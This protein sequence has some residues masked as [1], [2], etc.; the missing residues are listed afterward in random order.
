MPRNQIT[1][2]IIL[3]SG[4]IGEIHKSLTLLTADLGLVNPIAHGAYKGKSKL[5]GVTEIYSRSRFYLYHD[6][7]RNNYKVSDIQ[8]L[9]IFE[10]LRGDLQKFYIGSLWS[11]V[12]IKTYAGGGDYAGVYHLLREGLELLD[13]CE[14]TKN[15]T[16]LALFLYR[17]IE[18]LGYLPDFSSCSG[19]GA[20]L[21]D[22]AV[23][24]LG[25]DGGMRCA[26]CG[27]PDLPSL[28]AGAR[29]YL[30]YATSRRMTELLKVDLDAVS[31]AE[32]KRVMI[33]LI[34]HVI[35]GPLNSVKSAG[36]I[37]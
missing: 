26:R 11:E 21:T 37:L 5:G 2:G 36:G 22:D 19:C 34:Q 9:A 31:R 29:R 15:L 10:N 24:Y 7:V 18:S 1:E 32:L 14:N 6:P 33:S 8:P 4:R 27:N 12:V 28:S 35:G 13:G 20:R 3:K 30:L 23:W 25:G 16:V 17:Y